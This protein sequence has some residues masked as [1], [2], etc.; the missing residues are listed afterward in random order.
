MRW[1]E[2]LHSRPFCIRYRSKKISK[3]IDPLSKFIRAPCVKFLYN[4]VSFHL[5]WWWRY[6]ETYSLIIFQYAHMCFLLLF[7]YVALCDFFPLYDFPDVCLPTAQTTENRNSSNGDQIEASP[8]DPSPNQT[9]STIEATNVPYGFQRRTRPAV[10]EIILVVWIAT[11]FL[12][13]LRQVIH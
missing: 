9:N 13:E 8:M 7:S 10:S 12:E 11:L 1:F 3:F 2:S 4:L 6:D 5:L